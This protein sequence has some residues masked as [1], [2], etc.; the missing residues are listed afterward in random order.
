[1]RHWPR[2]AADNTRREPSRSGRRAWG[3][4]GRVAG[5]RRVPSGCG[6]NAEPAKPWGKEG[7]A[8]W[9]GPELTEGVGWSAGAG[10]CLEAGSASR[11]GAKAVRRSE[12]SESRCPSSRRRFVV[13]Y[14]RVDAAHPGAAGPFWALP[15]K[16]AT[17]HRLVRADC[18]WLEPGPHPV[19]VERSAQRAQAASATATLSR[20]RGGRHRYSKLIAD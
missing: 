4:S 7:R 16:S 5:Q 13:E 10:S 20:I 17:P 14:G 15:A 19:C 6:G 1:V 3:D 2:R 11:A 18:C 12:A 8:H 9:G